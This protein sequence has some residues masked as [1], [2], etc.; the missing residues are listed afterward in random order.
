M[1]SKE[2]G[3]VC[4]EDTSMII[5]IFGCY[6]LAGILAALLHTDM[7]TNH[8]LCKQASITARTRSTIILFFFLYAP[9]TTPFLL[10]QRIRRVSE[11]LT[12]SQGQISFGAN[13]DRGQ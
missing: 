11:V 5:F 12:T 1:Q 8:S 4:S 6:I 10:E 13:G 7:W 2:I 3:I 9:E